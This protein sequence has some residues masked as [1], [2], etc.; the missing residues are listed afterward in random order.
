LLRRNLRLLEL[1][2][3]RKL[4]EPGHFLSDFVKFFSRCQD[5]LVTPDGYDEYVVR[6]AGK[7]AAERAALAEDERAERE[8]EIERQREIARAYRASD[9]LLR[10]GKRLTFGMQLLDA[11]RAL[12]ENPALLARMRERFRYILVDEFQDTNIAQ[13]ELLWR[14]AGEHRNIVAVGDDAQAIYRFR[15]ASFGSFTIFLERFAGVAPGDGRAAARFVRPLVDNYRSTGRILRVAGQ[16]TRYLEHSPLVPKKDLVSHKPPGEK[17]RIASFDSAAEEAAWIAAEVQRLHAAAP[18][19][20]G[21]RRFAALYRIHAHRNDL[22]AALEARGIPFVIRNRSIL[23]QPLVRDLMAYL[24]LIA[25][26]WDNV[27]CARVLAAP[28][29][30]FE[31]ADLVRLAERTTKNKPSLWDAL[32]D[33]QS[34]LPFVASSPRRTPELVAGLAALRERAKTVSA[35]E[36]F[37]LLAE[38]LELSLVVTPGERRFADRMAHFIREWEKKSSTA[39]LAELIEY[40]D[41]FTQAGGQIDLDQD[42][43]DAVQLMTVHAAKGLEFDHVF[44]LRLVHRAFP[45]GERTAV[46]EFPEELMKEEL[47]DADYHTQEERRL[48]YVA[49]TRARERLTL[50]TVAHARA[51]PSL[52]LDDILSNPQLAREHVEQLN[53]E[54][55]ARMTSEAAAAGAGQ[56]VAVGESSPLFN[57]A[58]RGSRLHSRIGEWA[59]TYRKPLFEPLKLS[60]SAIETYQSCPQKHLF[61]YDW[62][63]RGGPHAATTFGNVM[64]TSVRE[65]VGT[66]RHGRKMPFEDVESF[67]ARRWTS[68]GFEDAYQEECYRGDGLEQLRVFHASCMAGVPEIIEQERPFTLELERNVQVTGRIDQ[69]NHAG[70]A[71]NDVEIVDYKTGRPKSEAHARGDL[72]LGVYALA[73]REALELRPVSLVYHNLENNQRVVSTRDEKQLQEV[74]G[75][76]QEVAADIRAREFP[77]RPGFSCRMC[78]YRSLCPAQEARSNVATSEADATAADAPGEEATVA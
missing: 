23:D 5:E 8:D 3:Y 73:A 30:G 28:A 50:T 66:L 76:I 75:A 63:L 53:P 46:L 13:L 6:L 47:P 43:D 4:A 26:P 59:R 15:G 12:D 54:M 67:Y 58:R 62:G 57:E 70:P 27:A 24:R 55:P 31:A 29:W 65:L 9:R 44:V 22:V 61:S 39:R 37:D 36:L 19:A 25:R 64:H 1:D 21:W 45:M 2:R 68:A 35:T 71:A 16:V 60:A 40:F 77:A 41:Y 32:Q 7:Y 17:V 48:F 56:D 51:K 18:V 49:V 33:A 20:G 74:R 42:A 10:E 72:Q 11:V 38:W 69:I 78:D 52:F 14:L 34:E